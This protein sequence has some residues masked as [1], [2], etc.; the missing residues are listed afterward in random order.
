[1]RAALSNPLTLVLGCICIQWVSLGS[2]GPFSLK[3]PYLIF[4]FGI[5]YAAS[6]AARLNAC[7]AFV[8]QNALWVA[9]FA[10]YLL[11]LSSVLFG[12]EGQN[13][14]LRQIFYLLCSIAIAGCLAVARDLPSIVRMGS[15]LTLLLFVVI[16]EVLART[17]GLSW[18]D[19]IVEFIGNGDRRFAVYTFFHG[20]FNALD[21]NA[22]ALVGT[23]QKNGVAAGVLVAALLFRSASTRASRDVV[24]MMVLGGALL[25]LFL[26]NTR[27]V[28]I[29]AGLSI[30][31]VTIVS[32]LRQPAQLPTLVLK[33]LAALAII[34]LAFGYTDVESATAGEMGDRFAFE[35]QSTAERVGQYEAAFDKIKEYPLTGSGYF[36]LGG[37]PIHNLFLSAWVNA[38]LAAFVLVVIFY[39]AVLS[40]WVSILRTFIAY[41]ERWV[42]PIAFEWVAALPMLPLFRV[43]LAGDGGHPFL[44]EWIGL[45]AFLGI[46]L[47][48]DLRWRNVVAR[49]R[50]PVAPS[51]T[52]TITVES[53]A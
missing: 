25:I 42:V 1:M 33:V 4:S 16:V 47:A 46:V 36:E 14:P 17:I 30:L 31:F 35:D 24:G 32:A 22:D 3:V 52:G 27:S 9:P 37:V 8:R 6:S 38:G 20:V 12:T 41:P 15:A 40:R 13:M 18:I 21:P 51:P 45:A 23:S 29:V 49:R 11:L 34:T 43:W 2:M 5:L 28:L 50:A 26:L 10:L 39:L 53:I 48:N 7:I 19:A 44:G